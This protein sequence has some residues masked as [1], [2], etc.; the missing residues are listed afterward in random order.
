M[1]KRSYNIYGFDC[2]N[3]AAKAEAHLSKHPNIAHARLDFAGNRLHLTFKDEPM[4][5]DEIINVISEVETDPITITEGVS[6]NKKIKIVT[7]DM[8]FLLGR[9]I[10]GVL[11]IILGYTAFYDNS[12]FWVN[13]GLYLSAVA[14]LSYDVVWKVINHIIHKEN[15]IDEYLLITLAVVGSFTIAAIEKEAHDFMEA[16]MVVGLFQIGRFIEGIATNKSKEAIMSAVDLRVEFANQL[17]DNEIKKVKPEQ[18]AI[19]DSIVIVAG[20]LI[21]IDGE[22][23]D[24]EGQIDTSS[25]TGE[26]VPINANIGEEIYSGCLLKSGQLTVKVTKEFKD[27]TV[28][29]IIELISNSGEKKSKAD[30]FITKFARWYTPIIFLAAIL[31]TVIAGAVTNKWDESVLTGLKMLVVACPCAI[32]ISVPLAYFSAIG[33]ASKNGVV[34]KGTNYLDELTKIKKI[35]TDKTGTLTHGSFSIQKVVTAEGINEEEFMTYL[36]AAECLSSHP[37]AKAICHGQ[38]LKKLAAEQKSFKDLT[39]LGVK[40]QY[41][42]KHIFAGNIRLM[43]QLDISVP[44]DIN[45]GSVTYLAVENKYYGYVILNDTIKDDAQPMVDLLHGDGIEIVLLTGDKE[46]NAKEICTSLGIDKWHSELLPEDKTKYLE[47]ELDPNGKYAVAYIGDGINDAA[48]IRLADV[49]VAMGG[50][51]SDV[52]VRN[53]DLVI[54]NDDPAK[55]WDSIRIAKMAR[56]TAIFNVV[57][58][59]SVKISVEIL[60]IVLQKELPMWACVLADTGLTVLLIINSLLILYRKV[61]R[62]IKK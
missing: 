35:V 52:A 4:S 12:Y 13:F 34:V 32:V 48:S 23:V 31:Y 58:A 43:A 21:P 16:V 1:V 47:N 51:G 33:L 59:L 5:I 22:V 40:T 54:M 39:G 30:K 49:G 62:K 18:L 8:F 46:E 38:N 17:V 26:Y 41:K 50:I 29:K 45:N 57:F 56:N 42:G 19:G 25:L 55:V 27:S 20:E 2:G 3:C 24:G 14:L 60:A 15:P 10:Y 44:N 53:A 28:N 11:I 9:V 61:N 37:I 7:K 36:Y 6:E